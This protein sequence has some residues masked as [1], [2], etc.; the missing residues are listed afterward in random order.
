MNQHLPRRARVRIVT[1]TLAAFVILCGISLRLS[2]QKQAYERAIGQTYARA[3]SVLADSVNS[4]NS[5]LE[6]SAYVTSPAMISA[7]CTQIYGDSCAARQAIS[8]LPYGNLELQQTAAFVTKVGDWAQ[9]LSRSTGKRGGYSAKELEAIHQLRDAATTLST[10]LDEL[11]A[12]LYD[13]TLTLQ[14][15]QA[16]EARLATASDNLH[17]GSSYES[18]ESDFPELPTLIYDGPF[19]DHLQS[20]EASMLKEESFY[21]QN[22]AKKAAAEFLSVDLT[23]LSDG[24][25][26]NGD[27]PC[28]R[29]VCHSKNGED[30]SVEVTQKG[31]YILSISNGRTIGAEKISFDKAVSIAEDY[32]KKHS[33]DNM[34][35]CYYID[36]GNSL[37]INFAS[38]QSNVLCYPDLIKVEVALDNGEIV[39]FE[40]A[41]Y[42][43]NHTQRD[44][45][46]PWVSATDAQS[47][48]SDALTV[49]SSRLTLIPTAGKDEQLCWEFTCENDQK[50]HYM[51]YVNAHTGAEQQLL[52]LLEDETGTLAE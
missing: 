52:I 34:K 12:Q 37:T 22:A 11:E 46:T 40:S 45:L 27:I 10:S 19:S 25:E 9:A 33:I 2:L 28:Y 3:F 13:G 29:F 21:S 15:T 14:N 23:Q 47:V 35:E 48:V 24:T 6:K 41:G 4:M 7:L 43:T 30:Y 26:V 32:L 38:E 31:G 42:L 49:Q 5:S 36:R 51:V 16:V 20:R 50:R 1:Y 39:G 18:I 8:E 17:T 44:K